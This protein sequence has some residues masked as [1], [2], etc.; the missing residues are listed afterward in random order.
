MTLTNCL[1]ASM[2]VPFLVDAWYTRRWLRKWAQELRRIVGAIYLL[3][4]K[5]AEQN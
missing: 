5:R 1:I 2:T 4:A 3:R